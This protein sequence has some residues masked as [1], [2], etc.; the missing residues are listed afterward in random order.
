[1]AKKENIKTKMSDLEKVELELKKQAIRASKREE[2]RKDKNMQLDSRDRDRK[3]IIRSAAAI[4]LFITAFLNY[5]H[6]IPISSTIAFS[7]PTY[8]ILTIDMPKNILA[9][10][11]KPPT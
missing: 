1:M 5:T 4:F 6:D 10:F 8:T 11:K 9:I 2:K 3:H 7:V